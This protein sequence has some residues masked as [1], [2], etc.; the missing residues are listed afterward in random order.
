MDHYLFAIFQ[1]KITTHLSRIVQFYDNF[2]DTIVSTRKSKQMF[3]QYLHS[4]PIIFQYC[5]IH[6]IVGFRYI[7]LCIEGFAHGTFEL[8]REYRF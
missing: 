1:F 4:L 6:I 7:E 5:N 2:V 8:A 3:E